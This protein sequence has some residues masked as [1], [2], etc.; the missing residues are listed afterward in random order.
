MHGR[1]A[2]AGIIVVAAVIAATFI[3]ALSAQAV[4]K[5]YEGSV[6]HGQ[7]EIEFDLK[8]KHGKAKIK[9]VVR[10]VPWNCSY[11]T[12]VDSFNIKRGEKV[13][14]RR[15]QIRKEDPDA[16]IKVQTTHQAVEMWPGSF[17]SAAAHPEPCT[18]CFP[19]IYSRSAIPERS[20]G[21]RRAKRNATYP[22]VICS[23]R[24]PLRR[25][26]KVW[27]AK[28]SEGH[29]GGDDCAPDARCGELR[30]R[31]GDRLGNRQALDDVP[32]L[33]VVSLDDLLL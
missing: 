2:L 22:R 17:K 26:A 25:K 8:R 28:G 32:V 11:G 29:A 7:G 6:A 16:G 9:N 27:R 23:G 10:S 13:T 21:A 3:S 19:T 24:F 15:F 14:D 5:H 30:R 4:K 33:P 1:K 18:R 20:N 12:S 31:D